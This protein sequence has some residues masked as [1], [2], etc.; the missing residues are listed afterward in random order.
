[1]PNPSCGPAHH[2][3]G[4]AFAPGADHPGG[5][6]PALA[7]SLNLRETLECGRG[8]ERMR[9]RVAGHEVECPLLVETV[10]GRDDRLTVLPCGE[11][12]VEPAADPCPVG[13]RPEHRVRPVELQVVGQSH[14]RGIGMHDAMPVQEALRQSGRAGGVHEQG[15]ILGAGRHVLDAARRGGQTLV[16]CALARARLAHHQHVLQIGEPGT[17]IAHTAP[18]LR[19]GDHDPRPGIRE[20]VLHG[21]RP[22]QLGEGHHD[23]AN[24]VDRE[25]GEGGLRPLPGVHRHR[26][27]R[28]RPQGAKSLRE[29]VRER[30]QLRERVASR[31]GALVL[32]DERRMVA[33]QA[34]RVGDHGVERDVGAFRNPD[35]PCIARL[36]AEEVGP[37]RDGC[38]D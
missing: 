18:G 11:D 30:I 15:R 19:V 7:R 35:S 5:E 28:A 38:E 31:R 9:H 21:V 24:L 16:E 8:H 25:V 34:A 14:G 26:L 27:A 13:R 17:G 10:L 32:E 36:V 12:G 23:R 29:P 1:M 4:Q 22:V 3:A 33:A 37:R 20:A 6:L 2:V